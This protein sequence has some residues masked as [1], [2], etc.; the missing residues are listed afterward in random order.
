MLGEANQ[1]F[2]LMRFAN[3]IRGIWRWLRRPPVQVKRRVVKRTDFQWGKLSYSSY[4]FEEF[5]P[6]T[7]DSS[8]GRAIEQASQLPRP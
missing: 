7:D 8:P 6:L 2:G 3:W 4:S 5:E 1:I